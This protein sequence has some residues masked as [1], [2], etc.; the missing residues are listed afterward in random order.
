MDAIKRYFNNN[1]NES[2]QTI[3]DETSKDLNIDELFDIVDYTDS[4]IGQQYLYNSL[5]NIPEKSIVATHE[6]W[7]SRYTKDKPLQTKTS[8]LIAKLD[9]PDAYSIYP[10]IKNEHELLSK[11][12]V[13]LFSILQFIP[14]IFL[15]LFILTAH[16][17]C[18]IGIIVAF[19]VNL[20]I[21]FKYKQTSFMYSGSIPQLYRLLV[22]TEKLI[23]IPDIAILNP[24]ITDTYNRLKVIKKS[25]SAFRFNVKLESDLTAIAWLMSEFIRTFFLFEPI[26]LDKIF[27]RIDHIRKDLLHIY[28]FIGMVDTLQSVS[29]MREHL[30][31]YCI[32]EFTENQNVL[33]SENIYHPLID[34]CTKNSFDLSTN[35]F[36]IMGSNMS[37]KTT[38]IRTVG[39]NILTAQTLNTSFAERFILNK[40]KIY[41]SITIK[42][43]L[44][45]GKSYYLSEV[46]R[47]KS[48]VE[49][50]HTGH[51]LILLDELFK[52]TNTIERIAGAKAV[53]NYLSANVR[54]RILVATHD[55]ELLNLLK[56]KFSPIYFTETIENREL[57]FD[58][59][60]KYE[61][62]LQ[63]NAIRILD[64]Y[65]YP[66]EI[67]EEALSNSKERL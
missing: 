63:R 45:D 1:D 30:E 66:R 42:D 23:R 41:T 62:P 32:P 3:D 36:L 13:L 4:A 61:S 10:L 65:D 25:L 58:Y 49:E 16:Y 54:N 28:E 48:I 18:L 43:N 64:I 21:H 8:K 12:Q 19:I 56:E 29:R 60:I 17:L 24:F 59:K 33:L 46:L 34:N 44:L 5:R 37:G 55:M 57:S 35:S 50:T 22:T 31:T 53:L 51:N 38:F 27:K 26:N 14:T 52:G 47:I 39:V 11:N 40:Q 15:A 9:D 6:E 2:F 67:I 7:I 20:I